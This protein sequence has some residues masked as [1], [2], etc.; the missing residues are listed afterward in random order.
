[1]FVN[2]IKSCR[3]VVAVCDNDLIGKCFDEGNLQLD[4]K[5]GFYKG[6]EVSYEKAVEIISDMAQE[7]ATF[8]IIG[9]E[10]VRAS[11]E[12]GI[13]EEDDVRKIQGVPFSFV[14]M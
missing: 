11:I 3:V 10:A 9:E 6:D 8:N 12:A 5:E 1:M 2:I 13:I 4:V 14:L 7:D